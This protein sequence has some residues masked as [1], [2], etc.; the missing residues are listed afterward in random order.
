LTIITIAELW[1]GD[2]R[3]CDSTSIRSGDAEQKNGP[4]LTARVGPWEAAK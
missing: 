3:D 2:R 1:V 4:D